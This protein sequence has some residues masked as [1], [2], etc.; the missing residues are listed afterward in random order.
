M[1]NGQ[2][3]AATIVSLF[4]IYLFYRMFEVRKS[5]KEIEQVALSAKNNEKH[6]KEQLIRMV[7]HTVA[8]N[9]NSELL[10]QNTAL[11]RELLEKQDRPDA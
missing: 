9:R 3:A 8:L 6:V 4:A 1:T 10:A 7:E 2:I 5:R 11:L